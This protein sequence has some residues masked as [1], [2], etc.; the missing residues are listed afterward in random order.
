MQFLTLVLASLLASASVYAADIV[1]ETPAEIV[2][3][4]E[5]DI[6]WTGGVDSSRLPSSIKRLTTSIKDNGDI[7]GEADL[8]FDTTYAWGGYGCPAGSTVVV[9]VTDYDGDGASTDPVIVSNSCEC[10][11]SPDPAYS[12]R[13]ADH[14]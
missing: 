1:V 2:Q 11:A 6:S 8:V 12:G 4:A 7:V 5:T 13:F 14:L 3:C 10:T 9:T